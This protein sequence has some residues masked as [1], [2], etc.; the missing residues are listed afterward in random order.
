ML[1]SLFLSISSRLDSGYASPAQL[2]VSAGP[3]QNIVTEPHDV[4]LFLSGDGNS[5]PHTQGVVLFLHTV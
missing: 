2:L 5:D 1:L 3:S 4:I